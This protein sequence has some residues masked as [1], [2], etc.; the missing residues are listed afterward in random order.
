[1]RRNGLAERN[2]FAMFSY[3]PALIRAAAEVRR[4]RL[5]IFEC[6]T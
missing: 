3:E 1:M 4:T 2:R 5:E 6:K